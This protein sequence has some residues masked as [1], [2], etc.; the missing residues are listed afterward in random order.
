MKSTLLGLH[1]QGVGENV[2]KYANE[3]ALTEVFVESV[4]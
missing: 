3:Y 2:N 4:F 1:G